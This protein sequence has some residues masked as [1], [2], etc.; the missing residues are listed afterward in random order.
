MMVGKVIDNRY[1]ILKQL[2]EGGMAKVLYVYSCSENFPLGLVDRG[3]FSFSAES[4]RGNFRTIS[5]FEGSE[6]NPLRLGKKLAF[7]LPAQEKWSTIF[8]LP[9]LR[10]FDYSEL[11]FQ[12]LAFDCAIIQILIN[13]DYGL[14]LLGHRQ[15]FANGML[16]FQRLPIEML[17]K[18]QNKIEMNFIPLSTLLV[19]KQVEIKNMALRLYKKVQP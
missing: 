17:R 13:E 14:Q 18:G 7:R 8:F 10:D 11:A 1:E 12:F 15:I 2:G 5:L 19:G 6:D 16:P 3:C 9:D 4:H